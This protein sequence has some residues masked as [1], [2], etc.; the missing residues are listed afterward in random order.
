M[1]AGD[2]LGLLRY[3]EAGNGRRAVGGPSTDVS[4]TGP[5]DTS[6]KGGETSDFAMRYEEEKLFRM[7]KRDR[8]HPSLI[9]TGIP[10]ANSRTFTNNGS[11]AGRRIDWTVRS[12]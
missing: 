10:V 9:A 3:E 4:T 1:D 11:N 12:S 8:S 7:V 2:R 6:G 5:V